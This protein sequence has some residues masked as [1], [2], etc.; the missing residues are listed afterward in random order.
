MQGLAARPFS[1]AMS[2]RT[3][4]LFP[5]TGGVSALARH[6][7]DHIKAAQREDGMTTPVR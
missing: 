3:C 2:Y 7:A 5:A 6:F 1:P 4:L